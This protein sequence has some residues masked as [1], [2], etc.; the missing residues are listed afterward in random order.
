MSRARRCPPVLRVTPKTGNLRPI[1]ST[2]QEIKSAIASLSPGDKALLTAELF[3]LETEPDPATLEAA[4]ERGL[5]DV[6]A[7]RIRP[8]D[9]VKTMLPGW[10]SK[11]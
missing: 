2:I 3:S 11:S 8:L 4:L 6:Q 7:G 5:D 1:M 9:D 10:I